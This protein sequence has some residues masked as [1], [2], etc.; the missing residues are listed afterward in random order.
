MHALIASAALALA[1]TVTPGPAPAA[2]TIQPAVPAPVRAEASRRQRRHDR[3]A[4]ATPAGSSYDDQ[5]I[6]AQIDLHV[7]MPVLTGD[8]GG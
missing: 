5:A 6:Q 7:M 1:T 8:G 4:L 2:E 3:I